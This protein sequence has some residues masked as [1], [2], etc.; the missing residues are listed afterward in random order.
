M[1]KAVLEKTFFYGL[2]S[3]YSKENASKAVNPGSRLGRGEGSQWRSMVTMVGGKPPTGGETLWGGDRN[4]V[5]DRKE[6]RKG[7]K[8]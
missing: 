4:S 7:G 3:R 2:S 8:G 1:G 5:L 6:R